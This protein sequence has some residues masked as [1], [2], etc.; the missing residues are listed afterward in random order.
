MEVSSGNTKKQRENGACPNTYFKWADYKY[1]IG[2]KLEKFYQN[3][4]KE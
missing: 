1:D 4:T 2:I 3:R